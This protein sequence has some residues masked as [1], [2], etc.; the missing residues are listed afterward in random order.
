M[1]WFLLEV[2]APL[3]CTKITSHHAL[4][5]TA[6][7]KNLMKKRDFDKKKS[8][9]DA[10]YWSEYKKLRNKV[11]YELRNRVQE[12]YRN[13]VDETQNN[14]KAMWKTIHKRLHKKSLSKAQNIIT[15]LQISEAFNKHF[16]TVEPKLAEK[17]ISQPLDDPLR[18]LGNEI[19]NARF[20]LETVSVEY[21]E[22]AIRA[23]NK[24]KSPG[25]DR[26][27]VKILKDAVHLVSKPLTLIYNASL[28]RVFFPRFG[29]WLE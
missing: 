19:N 5:I 11:T 23:L 25:A 7:L 20:K 29:H 6:D 15:P 22:R 18:Y 10:S 4:W 1:F 17:V 21:V 14:P 12:Y 2:H 24:S 13:L 16:T 27:L 3:K 9:K 28:E 26:I 8:E